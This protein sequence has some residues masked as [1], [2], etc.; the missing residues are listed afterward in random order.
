VRCLADPEA[1]QDLIGYRSEFQRAGYEAAA[2]RTVLDKLRL[3]SSEPPSD[4]RNR[5]RT[6]NPDW[7]VRGVTGELPPEPGRPPLRVRPGP[8]PLRSA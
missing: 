8:N 1:L 4:A 2:T 3:I 5:W 6:S 7:L